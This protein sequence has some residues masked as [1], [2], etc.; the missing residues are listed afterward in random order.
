MPNNAID[1]L[2]SQREQSLG[3]L[4]SQWKVEAE[5]LAN[6]GLKSEQFKRADAQLVAKYKMKTL[7]LDTSTKQQIQQVQQVQEMVQRKRMTEQEGFRQTQAA[8]GGPVPRMQRAE[9]KPFS[10]SQI[11]SMARSMEG[12]TEGFERSPEWFTRKSKEPRKIDSMMRE[13][14]GWLSENAYETFTPR[15]QRQAD[16]VWDSI[17]REDKRFGSW[18]SDKGKRKPIAKVMALREQASGRRS[19]R[20]IMSRKLGVTSPIGRSVAPKQR[21]Q[22]TKRNDPLGL[23]L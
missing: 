6:S 11:N 12:F 2:N 20:S 21:R 9:R 4:K 23:G 3:Y 22:Q 1:R 13:Y 18:F 14:E 19:I 17:M 8:S 10:W 5:A 16:E 7:E 15:Q